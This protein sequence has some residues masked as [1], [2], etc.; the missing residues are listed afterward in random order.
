MHFGNNKML[1]I[2]MYINFKE[3][4]M[5]ERIH[6]PAFIHSVSPRI[7][8]VAYAFNSMPA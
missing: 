4:K 7:D 8:L 2:S 3:K 1:T 6:A 5:Q